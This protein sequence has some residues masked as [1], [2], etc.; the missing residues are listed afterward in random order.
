M[1]ALITFHKL[2]G[3]FSASTSILLPKNALIKVG[4]EESPRKIAA[5]KGTKPEPGA[6]NVPRPILIEAK[7]TIIATTIR[8]MLLIWSVLLIF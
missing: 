1:N 3:S 6:E 4:R 5:K 7:H 8:T 2:A